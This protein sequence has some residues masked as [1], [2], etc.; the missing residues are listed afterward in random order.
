MKRIFRNGLSLFLVMALVAVGTSVIGLAGNGAN[1]A[2]AKETTITEKDMGSMLSSKMGKSK[3][4]AKEESVFVEMNSDGSPEKITVSD[5]LGISDKKVIKDRSELNNIENLYGDEKF[6]KDDEGNLIWENKGKKISYQ[7]T[8]TKKPPIEIEIKYTLDGKAITPEELAGKSGHVTIEYNFKNTAKTYKDDFVPF[9]TLTGI[10]LNEEHFDNIEI[11]NGRTINYNEANI[12]VGF[13]LPG[14]KNALMKDLKSS[15]DLLKDATI[16]EGFKVEADATDCQID[17]AL[18]IATCDLGNFDIK[19]AFDMSDIEGSMKKLQN[20]ADQLVNG[21]GSLNDGVGKL[22]DGAGQLKD[23]AFKLYDGSGKLNKGMKSYESGINKF[24]KALVSSLKKV[25]KGT[26][27]LVNGSKQV[28]DGAKNVDKGAGQLAEGIDKVSEGL[29]GDDKNPGLVKGSKQLAQ[30]ADQANDG[31]ISLVD[32]LQSSPEMIQDQIDDIM[33]KLSNYGISSRAQLNHIANKLLSIKNG[34]ELEETLAELG[35]GID[36]YHAVL[37]AYYSVE[38]LDKVKEAL[39]QAIDGKSGQ[40]TALL[41]GMSNL[42]SGSADL[43]DG[44][45]QLN[46]G[47]KQLDSGSDELY[48]GTGKLSDGAEQVYLGVVKLADAAELFESKI[49]KATSKLEKGSKKLVNA[50]TD[51]REGASKI[52]NATD[53]FN[54]G[55]L[56]LGDGAT[57]L[58]KGAT[59]LNDSGIKK[60]TKLFGKDAKEGIDAISKMLKAGERYKT[61]SGCSKDMSGKVKFIF[62]AKEITVE[63]D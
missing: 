13:A 3:N 4:T 8:T 42:K 28:S 22:S 15:K 52:Y 10:L 29:S 62:K 7:G 32:A 53:E 60:I 45:T 63:E 2:V 30:G 38:T 57:K 61:F 1:K 19:D 18:T 11:D 12:V 36:E 14:L 48:K 16:P 21:L 44:L 43:S 9:V 55:I 31:V 51:F 58:E 56:T 59:T 25:K 27:S 50:T 23:G 6:K 41:A 33:D 26:K 46:E 35:L 39:E 17:M 40:I 34:D 37:N 24:D 20:G 49:G 54:K 5:T 47:V